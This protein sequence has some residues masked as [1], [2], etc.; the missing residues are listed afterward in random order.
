M[1]ASM[2]EMSL[3]LFRRDTPKLYTVEQSMIRSDCA[4]CVN[5]ELCMCVCVL[6]MCVLMY[7]IVGS[8]QPK[9]V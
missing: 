5:V 1:H 2:L 7:N 9:S 3:G 8:Y 4:R 6:C